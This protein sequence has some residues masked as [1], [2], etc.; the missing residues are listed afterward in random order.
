M[1]YN[2]QSILYEVFDMAKRKVMKLSLS[3]TGVLIGTMW[4]VNLLLL[5][6]LGMLFA[7]FAGSIIAGLATLYTGYAAT[8]TG[9]VIGF[10]FGFLHGYIV[11][12]V[13][14]IALSLL[15]K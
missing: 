6:L 13:G 9:A 11:G 8:L 7:G 12:F 14:D 5:A 15:M 1:Y 4:G 3:K 10:I 2:L